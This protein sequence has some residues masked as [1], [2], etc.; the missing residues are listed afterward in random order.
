[1]KRIIEATESNFASE[2]LMNSSAVL[3]D[4]WAPW[5]GPCRALA[6]K[7]E[8]LAEDTSFDTKIVKINADENAAL[9]AKYGVRGLP[10]MDLGPGEHPTCLQ[11]AAT[12]PQRSL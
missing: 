6:P 12:N 11:L 5:C 2:V 1:M 4:F 10:T 8:E 9:A 7:L 3:V